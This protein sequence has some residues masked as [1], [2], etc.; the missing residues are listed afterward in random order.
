MNAAAPEK[1]TPDRADPVLAP[2]WEGTANGELVLPVCLDCGTIGW[3][4][5]PR[6]PNCWSENREWQPSTGQGEIWSTAVYER[7]L[8]SRFAADIP[9]AVVL[10]RLDEGPEMIGRFFGAP[11]EAVIGLQVRARFVE[12]AEGTVLVDWEP[13]GASAG[14]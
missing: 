5:G 2:F 6:C 8:D 3:P 14:R 11:D 13:L 1:P 4:P 10:V 7:A 12:A 9:Y